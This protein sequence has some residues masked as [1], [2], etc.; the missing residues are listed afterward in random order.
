MRA[1]A[2]LLREIQIRWFQWALAEI[3]PSHPDVPYIVHRLNQLRRP[4]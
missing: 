4:L 3:N 2:P 1:F